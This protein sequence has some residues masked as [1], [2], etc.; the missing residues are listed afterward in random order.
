[1]RVCV[2]IPVYD[3]ARAI[4]RVVDR[5]RAS[6]LSMLL[7]D[8]GSHPDCAAVLDALAR[9]PDIILVR[10]PVNRGKGEAVL[11]AAREAAARGYTHM[12]QVDADA[13]HEVADIGRFVAAARGRPEALVLGAPVYDASVPRARLWGRHLTHLWV[14]INTLSLAVRDSMLGF[15]VYPLAALLAV[16]PSIRARRMEFDTEAVVRL[17]WFG[18]PVINLRTAVTYPVDGVSHFRLWRD[19][20]LISAMHARLFCG[21]LARAPGWLARRLQRQ[22]PART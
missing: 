2:A 19:N 12:V 11:T 22:H 21:M 17:V 16:A 4:G 3:H 8:D 13:Q 18:T 7:V 14:W 5:V 9:D 6:G 20:A 15:R 1:V 10:H